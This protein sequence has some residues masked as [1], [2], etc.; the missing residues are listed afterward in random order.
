MSMWNVKSTFIRYVWISIQL[1]F[2][3]H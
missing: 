3:K 1:F 2:H